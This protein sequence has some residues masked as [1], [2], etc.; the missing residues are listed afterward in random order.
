MTTMAT[1][2]GRERSSRFCPDCGKALADDP[3]VELLNHC[4]LSEK[5]QRSE[6]EN[7][8]AAG[9]ADDLSRKSTYET[10]LVRADGWRDRATALAALLASRDSRLPP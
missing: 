5:K 9:D 6:A 3:L 7:F 2:C 8:R 10:R 4:W 1:C